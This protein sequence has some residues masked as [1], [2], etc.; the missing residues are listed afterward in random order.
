[1]VERAF[2]YRVARGS[3]RENKEAQGNQVGGGCKRVFDPIPGRTRESQR[4]PANVSTEERKETRK[5]ALYI[6]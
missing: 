2:E 1:M 5:L 4:N 6:S 3:L